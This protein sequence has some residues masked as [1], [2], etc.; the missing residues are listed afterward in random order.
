MNFFENSGDDWR[1]LETTAIF[2]GVQTFGCTSHVACVSSIHM[3]NA[4]IGWDLMRLP[5]TRHTPLTGDAKT[6]AVLNVM[7][8]ALFQMKT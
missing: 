8:I 1:L 3:P 4:I 2:A 7:Q 5:T 6:V